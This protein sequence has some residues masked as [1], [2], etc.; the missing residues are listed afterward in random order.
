MVGTSS[1]LGRNFIS[2]FLS[3]SANPFSSTNNGSVMSFY[4]GSVYSLARISTISWNVGS[5]P[6]R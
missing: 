4:G 1:S 6:I 2:I 5:R 3:I